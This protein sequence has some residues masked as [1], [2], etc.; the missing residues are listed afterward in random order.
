MADVLNEINKN[1]NKFLRLTTKVEYLKA[2]L[3][4][5]RRCE[6]NQVIPKFIQIRSGKSNDSRIAERAVFAG[7]VFWLRLEIKKHFAKLSIVEREAYS[8]QMFLS[9]KMHNVDWISF[10][11]EAKSIAKHKYQKKKEVQIA[12]YNRLVNNMR[13]PEQR[14]I[15]KCVE[16]INNF[17]RNLSSETFNPSELNL[18]N[19]GF[20]FAI[21]PANKEAIKSTLIDFEVAIGMCEDEDEKSK[22]RCD[23]FDNIKNTKLSSVSSEMSEF[24]KASK[25]LRDKKQSVFF[26][27]ADKSNN[28]VI[29]DKDNYIQ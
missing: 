21:Q 2:D 9:N 8:T 4:F 25:S 17:V 18:L 24:K 15:F 28:I 12:K 23:V 6:K 10:R 11:E 14:K 27:K 1:K 22:M 29:L 19:R 20:N 26:T 16:P 13:I 3:N 7:Q 5:L